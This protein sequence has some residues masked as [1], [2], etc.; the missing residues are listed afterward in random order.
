M[1]R[2]LALLESNGKSIV[3]N[4]DGSF[5][6]PSQTSDK[7]YEIRL[8]GDR[9]VCTCPDFEYRNIDVCKHIH[10]IKLWIAVRTQLQNE[11]KP[12]VFAEDAIPCNRC[13]SIRTMK[14]GKSDGKQVYYCKDCSR[15]FR[16]SSLLKKARFNPEFVTLCLDLYFS[17]L[18]LRKI[19]RTVAN[20]FSIDVDFSTIYR[21]IQKYV[22]LVS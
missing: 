6:V 10:A 9:Y 1:K 14:Y 2:G 7:T 21:W 22:P 3:E 5:T 17:G 16:E 8:L 19:A 20:H 15:K 11:P 12:Q 13:G 18:S 4:A